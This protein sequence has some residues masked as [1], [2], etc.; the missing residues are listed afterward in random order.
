MRI[1]FVG[2]LVAVG[3]VLLFGVVL[4]ALTQPSKPSNEPRKSD[5]QPNGAA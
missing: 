2:M 4:Y 1:T 5:D 3:V